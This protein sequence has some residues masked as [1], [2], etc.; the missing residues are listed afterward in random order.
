MVADPIGTRGRADVLPLLILKLAARCN[1]NCTYCY[2]FNLAD[3]TWQNSPSHISDEVFD[4]VLDRVERYTRWSG[5][6]RIHL[7]MHGGEPTLLGPER[8]ERLCERARTRLSHLQVKISIQTNGVLLN[9]NWANVF[10]RQRVNIGVSIDGPPQIHDRARVDH[11]GRGSYDRVRRGVEALA[12]AGVPFGILTVI[13]LGSDPILVHRH[14]LEMGCPSLNYLMPDVTHDTVGDLHKR[15][16][17]TPCADFLIPIFD[18]WWFQST[19]EVRIRI[20]WD[21]AR[22][23]LGGESTV[24]ALGNRPLRF[25]VVATNGDI[26]GLDVLKAC[27]NGLVKTGMN[28]LEHDF[29]D[30][31]RYSP[32]HAK[33]VFDQMPLSPTCIRCEEM[34]TCAGGYHPHRFSR[35]NGF[36]NPSVWCADI[37]RLFTHIRARLGVDWRATDERRAQLS[38]GVVA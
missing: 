37:L 17:P 16:G 27:D 31:E 30:L 28:V 8:F 15:Y 3:T 12:E 26:E 10:A 25:L 18:D 1:L 33:I 9:Q 32:L 38:Q 5:Q 11:A 13:P 35:V 7:S 21:I 36:E 34:K 22:A 24:D 6:S 19:L 20:F 29:W 23:I 14:F 2:E 4:A